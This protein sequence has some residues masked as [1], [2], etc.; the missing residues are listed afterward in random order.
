MLGMASIDTVHAQYD[1]R[2][3][4]FGIVGSSNDTHRIQEHTFGLPTWIEHNNTYV[5]FVWNNNDDYGILQTGEYTA[6]FRPQVCDVYYFYPDKATVIESVN[7][8]YSIPKTEI[9]EPSGCEVIFEDETRT[10]KLTEP[11]FEWTLELL[12]D[13]SLKSTYAAVNTL[14]ETAVID[15]QVELTADAPIKHEGTEAVNVTLDR[16]ALQDIPAF[17]IGNYTYN[18]ADALP[19][20]GQ[21]TATENNIQLLFD[22][23]N[24]TLAPDGILEIDPEFVG[25]STLFYQALGVSPAYDCASYSNPGAD[26]GTGFMRLLISSSVCEYP[27]WRWDIQSLGTIEHESLITDVNMESSIRA[28]SIGSPSA[29]CDIYGLDGSLPIGQAVAAITDA[30]ASEIYAELGNECSPASVIYEPWNRVL[31]GTAKQDIID[32][33]NADRDFAVFTK[34]TNTSNTPIGVI[35]NRT[36]VL[37]IDTE[38]IIITPVQ[39]LNTSGS[40]GNWSLEWRPGLPTFE[41]QNY[42]VQSWNVANQEWQDIATTTDTELDTDS[43]SNYLRVQNHFTNDNN[44]LIALNPTPELRFDFQDNTISSVLNNT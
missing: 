5:P 41:T 35:F 14:D 30:S 34:Y 29:A 25:V 44:S 43:R 17:T 15:V 1:Y 2:G 19:L 8:I 11:N 23:H 13:N 36:A 31:S 21:V 26:I 18:F 24:Q 6:V 3:D 38:D 42:T 9:Y 20:L 22:N 16:A 4:T 27:Q 32:S 12:N 33:L 10:I 28:F 39:A 40:P 7:L 37:T